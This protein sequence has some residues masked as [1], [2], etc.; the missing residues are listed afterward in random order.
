MPANEDCGFNVRQAAVD[1]ANHMTA[2]DKICFAV[3]WSR[4]DFV[5][6]LTDNTLALY[7]VAESRGA[8]IGYA[9]LW[10]IADEGHITNVAVH[11][12]FRRCGVAGELLS[13]LM[14]EAENR[15]GICAF[16]LEVRISNE[17]GIKLYEGFG[18]VEAGRREGYYSDNK[19][20]AVI[21]WLKNG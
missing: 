2:L 7:M 13:T 14:A 8:L 11:P 20:D 5:K 12:S 6:E 18:F 1:D 15:A 16:T 17:A 21:M 10:C 9:G 19:E 3:P 4:D